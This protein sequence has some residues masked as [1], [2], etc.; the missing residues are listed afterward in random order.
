MEIDL[1]KL[2]TKQ[3]FELIEKVNKR[4]TAIKGWGLI[5]DNLIEGF[6]ECSYVVESGVS[7]DNELIEDF[8]SEFECEVE[9][10]F[11][12]FRFL[13][14]YSS[15]Q[16]GNY[17]PPNIECQAYYDYQ[18]SIF[19]LKLTIDEYNEGIKEDIVTDMP[20]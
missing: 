8:F 4:F 19:D 16:I 12:E 18:D 6:D 1:D 13:L 7:V 17:P 5:K 10:G 15:A 20:F 9:D 14:S 11:Y 3:V 2:S